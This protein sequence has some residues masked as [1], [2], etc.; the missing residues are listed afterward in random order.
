[1]KAYIYHQA[2]YSLSAKKEP[3]HQLP[4]TFSQ[5]LRALA[6]ETELKEKAL[7][8]LEAKKLQLDESKEWLSIKRVASY[9][10]LNWRDLSWRKLKAYGLSI[11]EPN[12]KIFDA[13]Y[14]EVNAYH[15][16]SWEGIYPELELP[17]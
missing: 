14:G 10:H 12:K 2:G 17:E 4:Q 11:N 15:V 3:A 8:D 1:M 13:N 16:T 9:N 6:D 5:A 7:I